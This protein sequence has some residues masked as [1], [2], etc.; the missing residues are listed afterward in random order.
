MGE[1]TIKLSLRNHIQWWLY[2]KCLAY[3]VWCVYPDADPSEFS[4]I[5][6]ANFV[7]VSR[8][9]I[10]E[11]I[12]ESPDVAWRFGVEVAGDGHS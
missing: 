1:E 11:I 9:E 6:D 4:I 7:A 5:D 10:Q 8:D 3:C 2:C 12:E